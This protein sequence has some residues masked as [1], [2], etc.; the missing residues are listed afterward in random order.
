MNYRHAYH[1][2]NFADV[3]KHAVLALVVEHLKK[4]DGAFL[5]LDTH[6][7][8]GLYDLESEQ[9][10]KTR[11]W[12]AGIGRV[13]AEAEAPAEIR[14]YLDVVRGLPDGRYPGSPWVVAASARPHDRLALCELHP[15]DNAQLKRLFAADRRVGVHHMDGYA[16][17]K[18]LLPP[19]ERRGLVLIDPPFEVKDEF[20]RMRRGM[21]QGLKRWPT[22]LYALWYPIKARQPVERFLADLAML[23]PGKL[24][25]AEV[26]T[27][28]GD[29]PATL[30]GCGL[31]LINPPWKL[32]ESLAALLPWLARVLSPVEGSHRLEWLVGEA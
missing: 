24:L 20:E 22:G 14:A 7:G 12:E 17:L 1:A 27:R 16:A 13:M 21:A 6:A 23:G 31:A 11:E 5:Y 3:I 8:I 10:G 2:G 32:D 4:K 18:A 15:E 25:V 29:D 9:A 19:P 30:N 26:M 28:A